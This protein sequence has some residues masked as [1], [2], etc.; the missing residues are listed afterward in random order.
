M[1]IYPII[2]GQK[3]SQQNVI[4]P[5]SPPAQAHA[6]AATP[7]QPVENHI[8]DNLINFDDTPAPIK[9]EN[10]PATEQTPKDSEIQGMLSS[11]GK[12]ANGPLL[13]FTADMKKDLPPT[14]QQ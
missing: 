6:Q 13:D 14:T 11:T 8:D 1:A 7:A 12:P 9:T 3:F 10:P 2:N 5:H 4:P